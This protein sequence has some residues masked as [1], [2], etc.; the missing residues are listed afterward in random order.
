MVG[1]TRPRQTIDR[2]IPPELSLV[3]SLFLKI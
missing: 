3:P 2:F 1:L